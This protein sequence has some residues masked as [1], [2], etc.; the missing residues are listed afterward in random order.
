MDPWG[1]IGTKEGSRF[2]YFCLSLPGFHSSRST[3]SDRK[4]EA[5]IGGEGED[6]TTPPMQWGPDKVSYTALGAGLK[7]GL[8]TGQSR[9]ITLVSYLANSV[10]RFL[11]ISTAQF[12]GVT[13]IV[14]RKRRSLCSEGKGTL[15]AQGSQGKP[16][17]PTRERFCMES[18]RASNL[19]SEHMKNRVG[20]SLGS[21]LLGP[22]L[23]RES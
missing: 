11:P 8:C 9:H 19:T 21:P 7:P 17:S 3:S 15:H 22:I 4:R 1:Q 12:L 20:N 6:T 18:A 5:E 13:H 14:G 16:V 2:L 10:A 23:L